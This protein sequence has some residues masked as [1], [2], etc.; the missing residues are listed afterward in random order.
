LLVHIQRKYCPD[1][2]QMRQ[3]P[4]ANSRLYA[5]RLDPGSLEFGAPDGTFKYKLCCV[6]LHEGNQRGG[7]FWCMKQVSWPV[8]DWSGSNGV[9]AFTRREVSTTSETG[10]DNS[11]GGLLWVDIS[12][13]KVEVVEPLAFLKEHAS[14]VV[15]F[16]YRRVEVRQSAHFNI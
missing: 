7:H 2:F 11:S 14:Q 5:T 1:N 3:Q 10:A 9:Q 16:M 15:A 13:D 8:P 12:D 6:V 4:D